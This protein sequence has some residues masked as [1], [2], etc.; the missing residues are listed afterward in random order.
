MFYT[1][2]F[3]QADG[4]PS[5][6]WLSETSNWQQIPLQL[7]DGGEWGVEKIRYV[8][9]HDYMNMQYAMKRAIIR[10]SHTFYQATVL[11]FLQML[12]MDYVTK[13][14]Y[15]RDKD[16][17][18]VSRPDGLFY[19]NEYPYE[20]HHLE[21]MVPSPISGFQ[22]I[23]AGKKDGIMTLHCMST[24]DYLKVSNDKKYWN[25]DLRED[26]LSQT[27]SLWTEIT[28][29]YNGRLF[30]MQNTPTEEEVLTHLKVEQEMKDAISKHGEAR[31]FN[32]V[33]DEWKKDL[34]DTRSRLAH[35]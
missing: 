29:G 10:P 16:L 35:A 17:I 27:R 34:K 4:V 5:L 33:E 21:Q 1:F 23:G 20:V 3:Y 13:I 18:F 15:N 2:E 31:P 6:Q 30:T 19:D 28:D 7:Q 11:V 32:R 14:T 24:K 9:D 25:L 22:D 26:L 12:S 8:D